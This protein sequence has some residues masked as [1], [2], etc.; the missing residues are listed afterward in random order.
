[1]TASR[2]LV[3]IFAADG[4]RFI[5]DELLQLFETTAWPEAE[6]ELA[7]RGASQ[8]VRVISRL[9]CAACGAED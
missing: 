7:V 8:G 4:T 1:M 6:P 5:P 2:C 3:A 9:A